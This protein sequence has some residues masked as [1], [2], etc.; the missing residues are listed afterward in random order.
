MVKRL[1]DI[2]WFYDN[3]EMVDPFD[4]LTVIFYLIFIYKNSRFKSCVYSCN[5]DCFVADSPVTQ[6]E[7]KRAV[8]TVDP[9]K[10]EQ[11][12]QDLLT[13]VFHCDKDKLPQAEPLE[14]D[15]V[16]ARLQYGHIKRTAKAT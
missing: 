5:V 11:Q 12:V 4:S 1:L 16:L 9:E 10:E 13:W 3:S 15:V 2:R 7:L 14:I 6:E 8:L